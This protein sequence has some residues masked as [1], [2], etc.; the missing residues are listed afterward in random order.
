MQ[1]SNNPA[2]LECGM[3]KIRMTRTCNACGKTHP[4]GSEMVRKKVKGSVLHVI[5]ECKECH[6]SG[7][8][9][10]GTL[11]KVGDRVIYRP[12]NT[13]NGWLAGEHGTVVY[14]DS[15]AAPYTV[16]FDRPFADAITDYRLREIGKEP[17]YSCGW[18][19]KEENLIKE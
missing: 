11:F 1:K 19:C 13:G 7:R 16:E 18:F 10:K 14:I 5:F 9:I 2:I 3:V 12:V 8:G 17:K 15:T 6:E 4:T